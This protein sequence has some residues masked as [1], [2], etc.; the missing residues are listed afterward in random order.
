[1][2]MR[3]VGRR[4]VVATLLV[5]GSAQSGTALSTAFTYQGQLQTAGAAAN[6]ACDFQFG[7][8]DAAFGGAQIG[9]LRA[10][11]PVA[12]ANG[13]FTVP[14]DFGGSAF[15]G[16]DRWLQIAVRCPTGSGSYA[17]LAPRQPLAATPYALYSPVAGVAND[18]TCTACLDA[19]DLANGSVTTAKIG[20][21]QVSTVKLS[22]TGSTSGQVL[23]SN[24]SG[25]VW[26]VP[27]TSSCWSLTGNSG[28]SAS[29]FLGTTD[30]QA[31]ELRVNGTRAM[32]LEPNMISPNVIGGFSGNGVSVPAV[33]GATIGGGGGDLGENIASVFAT[34]GGGV[35][36]TATGPV[37]A[38]GGGAS[39]VASGVGATVAGG[40]NNTA[41]AERSAV[42]GGDS[43]TAGGDASTVG[44]GVRNSASRFGA[45]IGG[46]SDNTASG[47]Y[48]TV[49]GGWTNEAHGTGSFAAGM[50]AHALHDRSF[51]WSDGTRAGLSAHLYD[52]N[53]TSVG[54]VEFWHGG[55][56]HCDLHPDS[57]GWNCTSDRTVKEN[58]V[59]VDAH[60][61]LRRVST[62]P[63]TWWNLKGTDPTHKHIGPVAQDFHAA[64]GLGEET[65]INTSDAQGVAFAAIK[66]L[67]ELMRQKD[68]A[69]TALQQHNAA[70]EARLAVLERAVGERVAHL[71]NASQPSGR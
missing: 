38:I 4:I 40:A 33:Y 30:N 14:L 36:N 23:T 57:V 51:V 45:T 63:V 16:N 10:A 34:V 44:G 67:Y 3:V 56:A 53:V 26:Q 64:F 13:L 35:K 54:G 9:G 66:G 6:D 18:V 48:S 46:G 25:V 61:T 27:S 71:D 58:F 31:L 68:A 12:V 21:A 41:S 22:A 52:F 32:R 1:M 8:F 15:D 5:C 2:N 24:G 29:A 19:A 62:L 20:D 69:I 50:N 28:T 47:D 55:D 39:N 59:P 7:L 17:T 42:G 43:N 70:L 37:T 65:M 11:S 60:D 49:P